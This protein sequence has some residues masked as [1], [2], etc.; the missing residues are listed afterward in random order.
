MAPLMFNADDIAESLA[1]IRSLT[2]PGC[3][4]LGIYSRIFDQTNGAAEVAI[5]DFDV[6]DTGPRIAETYD[7]VP[8]IL[9]TGVIFANGFEQVPS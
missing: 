1:L 9:P 2:A 7:C 5:A 8:T 3:A 4:D 6:I